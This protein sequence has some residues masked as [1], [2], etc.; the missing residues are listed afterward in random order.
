MKHI[1]SRENPA[2]RRIDQIRRQKGPADEPLL[3][4]EGFRLCQDAIESGVKVRQIIL[5]AKL[6][7]RPDVQTL[8]QQAAPEEETLVLAEHLFDRLADTDNPQGIAL[9]CRHP[10]LASGQ[11]KAQSLGLYLALEGVADPGNVGTLIRTAD[12]FAFHGVLILPGTA[13]P[14]GDKAI[15]SSMGSCFHLPVIQMADLASMRDWL[16]GAGLALYAA[17]MEGI[18]VFE[19]PFDR[20][21]AILVGNEA[22]GLSDEARAI[23]DR[24]VTIPMPGRAESLNAAA[25]GAIL[26][27]ELRRLHR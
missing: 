8:L 20:H 9:L 2:Y 25:A 6:L 17:D 4:L 15:R 22:R 26:C 19:N 24:L 10:L 27:H 3:F 7:Q 1:E 21:G 5:T 13:N 14:F 23:C 16:A 18:S 11:K 12:A